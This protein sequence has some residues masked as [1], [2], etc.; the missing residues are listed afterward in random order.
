MKRLMVFIFVTLI[1]GTAF[2][3]CTTDPPR[4][5]A[6]DMP[7]MVLD[8]SV[9]E[10]RTNETIIFIHGVEDVMYDRLTLDVNNETVIEKINAFSIEFKTNLTSFDLNSDVYREDTRYN[11][12]A[13]IQTFHNDEITH[14]FTLL[15]LDGS[16]DKVEPNELP[17]IRRY[18]KMED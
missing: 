6:Y 12:N 3:G 18:N 4:P 17:F 14:R 8:Y 10:E 2:V 9:Q 16:E 11:F 1:T 15:Y 7:K 13:T 5:P